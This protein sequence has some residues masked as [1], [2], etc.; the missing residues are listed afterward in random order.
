MKFL[1]WNVWYKEDVRSILRTLKETDA[2]ILCLQELTVDHPHYN[3]NLDIP[4]IIA[5]EL[6]FDY[7]FK[8]AAENISDGKVHKYGNGIF[9][10]FPMTNTM[11]VFIQNP[12]EPDAKEIDYSK[13]GRIYL[14]ADIKTPTGKLTVGTTH[15]SYTDRFLPTP[16]KEKEA[17][18]LL[19]LLKDKQEK[20]L[21]SGDLNALPDS[22]T[23]NE[24]SKLLKNC[25]PSLDE[26]TWTTKPFVYQGFEADA[27]DW[28]IDYCFATSDVH[29]KSAQ[30][31]QTAFSD[32]LPILIEF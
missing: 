5:K 9:S 13:E 21:F 29:V 1:Q 18:N 11:S 22:Y 6:R 30:V 19:E 10:R 27:L 23:V 20:F 8:P 26:K 17:N 31:V 25:G 7:Y 16:A 2:D 14:E 15:M 12:P 3:Q 4:Q 32:H 24:L 28:R